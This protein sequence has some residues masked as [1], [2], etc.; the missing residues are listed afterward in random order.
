MAKAIEGL[1]QA[2]RPIPLPARIGTPGQRAL[3]NERR[4]RGMEPETALLCRRGTERAICRC[5]LPGAGPSGFPAELGL[6]SFWFQVRGLRNRI[7]FPVLTQP[8]PSEF[9]AL[10]FTRQGGER[11]GLVCLA[12]IVD[13]ELGALASK[14][15]GTSR[16]ANTLQPTDLVHEGWIKLA[17]GVNHVE[18]REHSLAV[19]TC[20][21]WQGGADHARAARN[22]KRSGY[23]RTVRLNE[24]LDGASSNESNPIARQDRITRLSQLV[25]RIASVVELRFVGGLAIE[26]TAKVFGVFS[27]TVDSNGSMTRPWLGRELGA[28]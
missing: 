4:R 6:L 25:A 19:A 27:A 12:R 7:N 26:G 23:Q 24:A 14:V 21:M 22:Q 9:T 13:R 28:V 2:I 1:G 15:T 17:G 18:G 16:F 3:V 20:A 8:E 11:S 10:L 5:P